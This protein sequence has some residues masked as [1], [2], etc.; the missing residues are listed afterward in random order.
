MLD[1]ATR[2]DLELLER[3][4]VAN[5]ARAEAGPLDL[6]VI[7]IERL[8]S[9]GGDPQ[10]AARARQRGESSPSVGSLGDGDSSLGGVTLMR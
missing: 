1:Q 2:V 10:A 8:P 7:P 6:E 5:Q 3:V 4:H 9:R